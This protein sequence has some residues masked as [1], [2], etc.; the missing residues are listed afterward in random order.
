MNFRVLLN[1][2]F[3]VVFLRF[4]GVI[5]SF[6]TVFVLNKYFSISAVGEFAF[7]SSIIMI[8]A[9]LG[10]FGS[11]HI[12]VKYFAQLE[13]KETSY[14]YLDFIV[15]I[16][17]SCFLVSL[18]I[19]LYG[20]SSSNLLLCLLVSLSLFSICIGMAFIHM[21]RGKGHQVVATFLD[22][23]T[24]GNLL[25]LVV[26]IFFVYSTFG[27]QTISIIAISSVLFF[28]IVF[29]FYSVKDVSNH[30]LELN[31][32]DFVKD[33]YPLMFFSLIVVLNGNLDTILLMYFS[34]PKEVGAYDIVFKI[35]SLYAVFYA[36][37]LNYLSPIIA[38]EMK[39][40]NTKKMKHML[41]G[42][43]Y[44]GSALA[45]LSM[46]FIVFCSQDIMDY[47]NT[48]LKLDLS[49]MVILLFGQLINIFFGPVSIILIMAGYQKELMHSM[50]GVLFINIILCLVLIPKYGAE[51]AAWSIT[52]SLA[53]QKLYL[54]ILLNRK[55]NFNYLRFNLCTKFGSM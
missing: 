31:R 44:F 25:K 38:S 4:I 27:S 10:R 35:T 11:E 53:A 34:G 40:E 43:S 3:Q 13:K 2:S 9:T 5:C 24:L 37:I 52:L 28:I 19:L 30:R 51:G 41:G 7:Y 1:K 23:Q 54:Y 8:A 20:L 26:T 21:L 49:V 42:V 48:Q 47:L 32:L 45:L 29:L 50:F 22:Y 33:S 55:I 14:R 46:V 17:L 12:I 36:A 6:S 39:N 15:P 18:L 16:G